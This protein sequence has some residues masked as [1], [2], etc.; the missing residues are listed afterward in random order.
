MVTFTFSFLRNLHTVFHSGCTNLHSHRH[1]L[2]VPFS[3]QPCQHLLFVVFWMMTILT[4]VKWYLIVALICISLMINDVEHLHVLAD[5]LYVF[6]GNMS[7]FSGMRWYFNS[8][9]FISLHTLLS[10]YEN[11]QYIWRKILMSDNDN[12]FLFPGIVLPFWQAFHAFMQ[13]SKKFGDYL[14]IGCTQSSLV[15]AGFL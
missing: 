6:F 9:S 8:F 2:R 14:F 15:G 1:C 4:D 11:I 10:Y 12:S 3:P 5:H 7:L 13:R